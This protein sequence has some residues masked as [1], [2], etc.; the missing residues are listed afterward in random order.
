MK[1]VAFEEVDPRQWDDACDRSDDAWLFHRAGW[2]GLEARH[3]A[4]ANRSF[5]IVRDDG[6]VVGILPLYVREHGLGGWTERVIDCGVHRHSGLAVVNGVGPGDVRAIRHAAITHVHHVATVEGADRIH[7]NAQNLAPRNLSPERDD[8][9]FWVLEHG[10]QLGLHFGR[11]GF[12]PVPGMATCCADQIVPL[13]GRTED[14]L[15]QALDEACRRA[16][17]KAVRSGLRAAP[18]EGADVVDQYY[19]LAEKSAARTGERLPP[20]AYYRAIHEAFAPTRRCQ[21]LFAHQGDRP[22]AA[23]LL[24]IDKAAVH[25]AAG[26]SDPEMLPLR[27]NDF[28]HWA[29]IRWARAAG[30]RCYRLGP[31]F[32][33]LPAS[34]PLA[35]V[36]RFKKK[37]GGRS[38][39][40]IQGSYYLRPEKYLDAASREARALGE[41]RDAASR[42]P[43]DAEG[44][45]HV[46]GAYGIPRISGSRA[47]L[48]DTLGA[49]PAVV[50]VTDPAIL[51][52]LG[53]RP[54]REPGGRRYYAA[55]PGRR[56]GRAL[57]YRALL[58]HVTFTG[59]GLRPV[60]TDSE[61]RSVVA[62]HEGDAGRRLLVGLDVEE[63]IVRYRQGDPDRA[64]IAAEGRYGFP[65]ERANHLY[66][67]QIL[68]DHPTVPWADRLGFLVAEAWARLTGGP[69]VEPL[70]GGA[71]GAVALTG[72]DDQAPLETYAAQ[73]RLVGDAPF[74]YFL[75][76]LTKHDAGTLAALGAAIDF[77]LHP[78]AVDRPEAYDARCA[79]QIA[80]MERL[81]GRKVRLVRNHN[82]LS[83]G[84]L[85][86]LAAWER[87]GLE[88]DVNCSA[89]DGTALTG[90]FVPMRVRG[91]GGTWSK[92]R[93]LLT[94]FGDGMIFALGMSDWR[95]ARRVRRLARQIE[96]TS[97][98]VL[99]VNLHP[100]NVART[101]RLHRA[102]I[103]LARRPGWVAV[104]LERFL[105]WLDARDT[106]VV[107]RSGAA[108]VVSARHPLN[109][110]VLRIPVEQGWRRHPVPAGAT[111]ARVALA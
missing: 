46:L 82:Y 100:A 111:A 57:A 106:I 69:L 38:V 47:V 24:L 36:S 83:R 98:G 54:R 1:V 6:A 95:A 16:V 51:E 108:A 10:Y 101:R 33:E 39:P 55:G 62:W 15:F 86:H 65:T 49:P 97:P 96:T 94:Q 8:I 21:V 61:G 74:T 14:E 28:V 34:W 71:R 18:G 56:F 20:I 26:A 27:T 2:V 25:F 88:L 60:W 81:V 105:D 72:D 43:R 76:P 110:V 77:G 87:G 64:R 40:V 31:V 32:P 13:A 59:P 93:T 102:A 35:R 22:A 12:V 7:L 52:P 67:E 17:R 41:A 70:P 37:F 29:A 19:A 75:H 45:T 103:A 3:A 48:V 66:D 9:P 23:L 79:E 107:E 84:Y 91:P 80:W 53:L 30:H 68:A 90:S 11:E 99:V 44:L 58:P 109:E 92:H 89:I 63:E 104:R 4:R 78:D 42:P 85:G 5:A 73:R 50:V